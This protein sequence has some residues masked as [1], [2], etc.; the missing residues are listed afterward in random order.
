MR[1]PI[2]EGRGYHGLGNVLAT[3]VTLIELLVSVAVLAV[4]LMVAVPSF[5]AVMLNS[6]LAA[7]SNAYLSSLHL[8]RSEAIKRRARVA[9]CKSADG[10]GCVTSGGWEQGWL[11]FHDVNNNAQ[12]NGGESVI[13]V[14]GALPS[15]LVLTGNAPVKNYVSFTSTG[16]AR[17]TS[18]A[19]QMG[20]LTLCRVA[21]GGGDARQI[22]INV[23]GRPR[24]ARVNVA[25]CPT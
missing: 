25:H 18:G 21:A 9:L 24:V 13:Q 3:G 20:T 12:V 5:D 6:R 17:W 11:V 14:H 15:G 19:P 22:V 1:D 8:A 2:R 16:G 23:T 10:L 4:L 7:L